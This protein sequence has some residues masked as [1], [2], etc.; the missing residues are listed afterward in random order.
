MTLVDSNVLIDILVDDPAS[1]RWSA[2]AMS[3]RADR[4][5]LF[6]NDVIFA[7]ISPTLH[8]WADVERAL[9]DLSIARLTF[10]PATLHA[11]GRAFKKY[12][13]AGGSRTTVLPDF[14]IGAQ[15]QTESLALLTRDARRYR[16][17]FP[18]ITLIAP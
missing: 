18:S 7:E 15:A 1:A 8:H 10:T 14:L 6:V 13:L 12:R 17:Y 9:A 16:T 3:Q 2:E 4:G 5:G 11:A